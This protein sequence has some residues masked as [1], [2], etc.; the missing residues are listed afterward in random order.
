MVVSGDHP[1]GSSASPSDSAPGTSSWLRVTANLA[2]LLAALGVALALAELSVR[3]VAPQQLIVGRP[4][5]WQPVDSLGWLFR[6]RLETQTNTG[7][8]TVHI[9]T[10]SLGLRVGAGGRTDSRMRVLLLGDSFMAALQVEHEQSTAAL[11]EQALSSHLQT[12]LTVWNA[13]VA[14]W[15][16]SQYLLRARQLLSMQSFDA[17]VVALYL[18]ND[19]VRSRQDYLPPLM[20]ARI[21]QLRLPR[22]FRLAEFIDAWLRPVNDFLE[23]RSHLF[24]LAKSRT[25]TLLMRLGLTAEYFPDEFRKREASSP[26]W[27]ITADIC[28]DIGAAAK[29]SGLPLLIALIPAPFQVERE[30]FQEYVIGFGINPDSVD[31][32]QPNRLLGTELRARGLWVV[33]PLVAFRRAAENGV[34]LFGPVDRHFTPQGH[35]LLTTVL[36]TLLADSLARR[37][38]ATGPAD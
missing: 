31:L 13:G 17:V 35:E 9:F 12:T 21:A 20:P 7:E 15:G 5:V 23:R 18:G 10:D 2:V 19:V 14:G 16:P 27:K 3:L 36:T 37:Q 4:D 32:D 26:R 25:S 38:D 34:P 24:I 28:E 30:A 33:D 29:A 11:L 8:R 22:E 6:P 1:S